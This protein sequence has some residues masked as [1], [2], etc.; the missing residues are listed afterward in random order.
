[1]AIHEF[2]ND[3]WITNVKYDDESR[4]MWVSMKG[5]QKNIY[6]CQDVPMETFTG[7]RSAPSRGSYFNENIKGQFLHKWFKE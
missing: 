4:L 5:G 3:S 1:M 6:E 2:D 7:F